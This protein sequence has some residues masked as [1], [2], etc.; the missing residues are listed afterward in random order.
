ME[1]LPL[2]H[3]P[4]LSTVEY[5]IFAKQSKRCLG[6]GWNSSTVCGIRLILGQK[7]TCFETLRVARVIGWLPDA[8]NVTRI[9]DIKEPTIASRLVL[10]FV[11]LSA[12][13]QL[14]H[15]SQSRV[16]SK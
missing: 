2:F 14:L 3:S 10:Y 9:N 13:K 16:R 1:P 6:F 5:D 11:E 12:S 15:Y 7:S 8:R 4:R